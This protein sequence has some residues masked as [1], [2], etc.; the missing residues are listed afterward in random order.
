[1]TPI[2]AVVVATHRLVNQYQV[3]VRIGVA[4]YRGSFATLAFG[5]NKPLIGACHDRRLDLIYLRHP[6]LQAGQQFRR[7]TSSDSDHSPT[8]QVPASNGLSKSATSCHL[9]SAQLPCPDPL[10]TSQR[11]VLEIPGSLAY[12]ITRICLV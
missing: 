10:A 3:I 8:S 12:K 7:A 9:A 5:E 1:M 2:P 11:R 4:N 6:G